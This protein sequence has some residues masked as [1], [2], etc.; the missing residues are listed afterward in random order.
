MIGPS[1]PATGS[2]TLPWI[3]NDVR[4]PGYVILNLQMRWP[5]PGGAFAGVDVQ[6]TD[7]LRVLIRWTGP[8]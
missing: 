3:E 1:E 4:G 7:S 6:T 5:L 2:Y 8:N